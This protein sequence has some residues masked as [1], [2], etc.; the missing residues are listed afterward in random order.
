MVNSVIVH[1][2]ILVV[3]LPRLKL[4]GIDIVDA[5]SSIQSPSLLNLPVA[6][7]KEVNYEE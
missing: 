2:R 4:L 6:S 7:L 1:M 5:L 3:Y